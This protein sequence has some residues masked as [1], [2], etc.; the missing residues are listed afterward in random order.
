M[1]IKL[2][3]ENIIKEKVYKCWINIKPLNEWIIE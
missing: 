3:N 2:W 1:N